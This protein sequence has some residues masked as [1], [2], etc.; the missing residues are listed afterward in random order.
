MTRINKKNLQSKKLPIYIFLDS[1]ILQYS[2]DKNKSKSQ[3]FIDLFDKLKKEGYDLAVS[4]IVIIEN[5]HGLYGKRHKKAYAHLSKLVKKVVS[6]NVLLSAA[7][8]G[9]LYKDE[10]FQDIDIGDKIIAATAFLD[11]GLMLTRNHKHFPPP[12]FESIEWFPVTFK[13][14]GRHINTIDVCLY[15]P[16]YKLIARRIKEKEK[17]SS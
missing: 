8:I 3:A 1:N 4:E 12:F 16:R 5:L 11:K 9:G 13:T 6:E 14:N 7:E 15:K 2:A 17:A 10:E